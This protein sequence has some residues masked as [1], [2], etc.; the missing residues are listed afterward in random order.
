MLALAGALAFG[1]GGREVAADLLRGAYDSGQQNAGQ[2]KRD[3]QA[4]K[5]RA[6]Q[7]AD[8]HPNPVENGANAGSR[9]SGAT[10]RF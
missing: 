5:Q 7:T 3:M 6:E 10:D 8:R 2:V 9:P 4:G 1:L